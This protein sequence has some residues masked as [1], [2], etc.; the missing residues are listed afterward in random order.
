MNNFQNI[1]ISLIALVILSACSTT[2]KN[3]YLPEAHAKY[4]EASNNSVISALAPDEM[5]LASD[6][7]IKAEAAQKKGESIETVN[8]LAYL[9]YQQVRVAQETAF[10]KADEARLSTAVSV[11]E[12]ALLDARTAEADVAK[13]SLEV[14]QATAYQLAD[15]LVAANA[16]AELDQQLIAKQETQLKELHAKKTN[17]GQV[18]TLGDVLFNS[19]KSQLKSNGTRQVQK[20]ADFLTNYP[21][22]MV[23]I[24]GYTDS[25]GS[26][27]KNQKLSEQRA[28]SVRNALV[29]MGINSNRVITIGYGEAFPIT[30]NDSAANRQANRRVEII[31]SD[32]NGKTASR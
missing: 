27:A 6:A 16:Q 15:E 25:I 12:Q 2:A 19:S 21:K 20:L 4:N 32:S 10:R 9:S 29:S 7:L 13:Q 1:S 18:I 22:N 3:T 17:R 23:L 31:V 28:N 26:A 11:R 5:K 8:H 30:S 24:E 14:A